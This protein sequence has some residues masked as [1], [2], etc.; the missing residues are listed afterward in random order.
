MVRA[1]EPVVEKA[2]RR[3]RH[4]LRLAR[5]GPEFVIHQLLDI[6]FAVSLR[7]LHEPQHRR[8][9][10]QQAAIRAGHRPRQIEAVG[11]HRPLVQF[12]VPVR[13]LQH[14]DPAERLV[15][16]LAFHVVHVAGRHQFGV[17]SR[18][19]L[20]RGEFLRRRKRL[21]R[22]QF[23]LDLHILRP[24]ILIVNR[25][26]RGRAGQRQRPDANGRS[27]KRK[28]DGR[29]RFHEFKGRPG[30]NVGI[31]HRLASPRKYWRNYFPNRE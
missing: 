14:H 27:V 10:H 9:P 15:F 28:T 29:C 30:A 17:K 4:V 19:N 13:I 25:P 12:P 7:V 6:G 5:A 21:R 16:A 2:R 1:V 24:G 3:I 8:L 23:E 26:E 11:K 20:E 31:S 18:R 22:R